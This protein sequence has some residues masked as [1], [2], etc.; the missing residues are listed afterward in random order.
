[1]YQQPQLEV[2]LL[3]LQ[4]NGRIRSEIDVKHIIKGLDIFMFGNIIMQRILGGATQEDTFKT[5][6]DFIKRYCHALTP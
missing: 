6:E 1:M 5:L 4:K 2:R 3:N